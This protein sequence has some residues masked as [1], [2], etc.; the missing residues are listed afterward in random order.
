ML[1]VVRGALTDARQLRASVVFARNT[2]LR[3]ILFGLHE[4]DPEVPA[5]GAREQDP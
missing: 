2:L 1:Y 5:R 3:D 4:E